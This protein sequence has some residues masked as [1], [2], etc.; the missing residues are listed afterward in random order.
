MLLSK[1]R[2]EQRQSQKQHGYVAQNTRG[3]DCGDNMPQ[4]KGKSKAQ[5]K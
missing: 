4:G 2:D 3:I 1:R 5:K